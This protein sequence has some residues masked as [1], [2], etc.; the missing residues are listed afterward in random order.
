[1]L[2]GLTDSLN[3]LT[4]TS[5]AEDAAQVRYAMAIGFAS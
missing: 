3:V 4:G 2:F 5:H 1:V